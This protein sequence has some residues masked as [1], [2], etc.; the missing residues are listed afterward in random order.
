MRSGPGPNPLGNPSALAPLSRRA[1]ARPIAPAAPPRVLPEAV[2]YI[3]AARTPVLALAARE[4]TCLATHRISSPLTA[5]HVA[6]KLASLHLLC[7][8]RADSA[9]RAARCSSA[10][11]HAT[12]GV[13]HAALALARH[14]AFSLLNTATRLLTTCARGATGAAHADPRA[15]AAADGRLQRVVVGPHARAR[16]RSRATRACSRRARAARRERRREASLHL[17]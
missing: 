15:H 12:G 11:P 3:N 8:A 16:P 9:R 14:T 5:K 1:E 2:R 10:R 13:L 17:R 4:N 7:A 6:A